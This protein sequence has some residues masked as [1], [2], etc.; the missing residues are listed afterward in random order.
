MESEAPMVRSRTVAKKR[1]MLGEQPGRRVVMRVL[2]CFAGNRFPASR[3]TGER[4]YFLNLQ[5]LEKENA[6]CVG[7]GY[8]WFQ[9]TPSALVQRS[10]LSVTISKTDRKSTRLNSSHL[11]IS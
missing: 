3:L 7:G 9:V 2:L 10:P 5:H 8:I 4:G 1:K 11:G 6:I